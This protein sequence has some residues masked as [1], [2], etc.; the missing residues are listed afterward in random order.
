MDQHRIERLNSSIS[1]ANPIKLEKSYC[2]SRWLGTKKQLQTSQ[3]SEIPKFSLVLH[4][5]ILLSHRFSSTR[6]FWTTWRCVFQ[7][8]RFGFVFVRSF[9][10]SFRCDG[11]FEF[12]GLKSSSIS[13]FVLV[14]ARIRLVFV[15]FK[16]IFAFF[17]SPIILSPLFRAPYSFRLRLLS[18]AISST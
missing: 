10:F 4:L 7:S 3:I 16:L 1:L 13:L 11:S 6:P 12:H 2:M 15:D 18:L 8:I 9:V 17:D 5:L 14:W